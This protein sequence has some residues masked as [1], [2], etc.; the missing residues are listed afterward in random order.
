VWAT[1]LLGLQHIGIF[2]ISL[3]SP[4]LIIKQA[5]LGLEHATRLVSIGMIAAGIGTITQARRRGPV[6]SGYLCPQ[7]C[8]PSYLS[9]SIPAAKAGGLSLLF[10][11][12]LLAGAFEVAF[13]R[14]IRRLRFLFPA[15]VTGLEQP[16]K[17]QCFEK[18]DDGH[19]ARL[20][21]QIPTAA[22]KVD[23]GGLSACLPRHSC[24]ILADHDGQ[25]LHPYRDPARRRQGPCRGRSRRRGW[26]TRQRR[27]LRPGE[28]DLLRDRRRPDDGTVP[29][30]NPPRRRPGAGRRRRPS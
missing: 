9:A 26:S 25:A 2:A 7:V 28:R 3:I 21:G 13:S 23:L 10:D 16:G 14:P 27:D 24:G 17:P 11:M 20:A 19:Q 30:R 4:I 5:G 18:L 22:I 6:G 8:G 12:T 29:Q 15:E 1:L